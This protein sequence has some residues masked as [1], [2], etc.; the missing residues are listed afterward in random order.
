MKYFF[1]ECLFLPAPHLH[2]HPH[3]TR[4]IPAPA[5]T[6]TLYLC[7]LILKLQNNSRHFNGLV[8]TQ[9]HPTCGWQQSVFLLGIGVA[10]WRKMSATSIKRHFKIKRNQD[11]SKRKRSLH[12]IK[13]KTEVIGY[14]NGAI[15]Y[16][17][18]SNFMGHQEFKWKPDPKINFITGDTG[19]GKSA[20]LQ[21]INIG[22]AIGKCLNFLL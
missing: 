5:L 1:S 9:E 13:Q 8:R 7:T 22:L 2:F 3:C 15:T 10:S 21:A 20:I 4:S 18:L 17:H 11:Y 12:N 14:G 19:N 6:P 16:I